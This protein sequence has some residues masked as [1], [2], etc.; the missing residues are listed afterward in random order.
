MSVV[1]HIHPSRSAHTSPSA[2]HIAGAQ[3]PTASLPQF[4]AKVVLIINVPADNTNIAI[5]SFK[6]F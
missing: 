4:A 2:R 5:A 3:S 1:A 6:K